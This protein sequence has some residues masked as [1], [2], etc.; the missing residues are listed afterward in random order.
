[1]IVDSEKLN[2]FKDLIS[3]VE[4]RKDILLIGHLVNSHLS[5]DSI[6]VEQICFMNS[7]IICVISG[8]SPKRI[9]WIVS[10]DKFPKISEVSLAW[11]D[12][13][14]PKLNIYNNKIYYSTEEVLELL[15]DDDLD[16]VLFNLDIFSSNI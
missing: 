10:S 7:S 6:Y 4:D 2:H 8:G 14:H 1:M 13:I 3:Q 9:H 12:D 5:R 16:F 11:R 15:I